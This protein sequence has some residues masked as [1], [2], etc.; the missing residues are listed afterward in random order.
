MYELISSK[1]NEKIKAVRKLADKKY[2]ALYGEFTVEGHKL[3]YDYLRAGGTPLRIFVAE[4]ALEKYKPL[5]ESAGTKEVYVVPRSLYLYMSEE[6]AP[7]G[8]MAV[9]P[10]SSLGALKDGCCVVLESLRDAGNL[11]T[12]IRTAVA[13]GIESIVL[14]ADCADLYNSKTLR[15]TMGALFF[16]NIIIVE[17]IV[18]FVNGLKAN[19]RRVFAAMPAGNALDVRALEV[20]DSDCMVIGNEGNGISEALAACCTACVT[21]PMR[22]QTESLNASS[23]ASVL[24]WELVRGG[25]VK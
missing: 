5:I 19:G 13:F 4:D 23:A 15:A 9:C 8:I 14:S 1:S 22:G 20:R 21:I 3:V 16:A 7:Q 17:D 10:I 18:D 11:G 2:R 24:M 6:N 25:N 12:V